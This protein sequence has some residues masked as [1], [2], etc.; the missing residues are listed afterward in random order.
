M[1]L[2][3]EQST[4]HLRSLYIIHVDIYSVQ[5]D[6]LK[7]KIFLIAHMPSHLE[8]TYEKGL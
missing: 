7:I 4:G 8:G 1:W 2:V 3:S 5:L 6:I